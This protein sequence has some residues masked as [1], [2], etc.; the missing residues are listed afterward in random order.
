MKK[1]YPLRMTEDLTRAVEHV[2]T[3]M[4][5]VAGVRISKA[6]LMRTAMRQGLELMEKSIDKMTPGLDTN[7]SK[8]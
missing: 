7:L 2:K 4:E 6:E 8:D 3:R 1:T 5:R